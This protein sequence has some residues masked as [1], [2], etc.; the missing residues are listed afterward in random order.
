LGDLALV[1]QGASA[2]GLDCLMVGGCR[3]GADHNGLLYDRTAEAYL[4]W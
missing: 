4:V 1:D 3:V 2:A